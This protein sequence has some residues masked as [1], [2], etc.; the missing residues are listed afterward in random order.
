MIT[1]TK[2]TFAP[3][4]LPEPGDV[5]YMWMGYWDTFVVQQLYTYAQ[6][7]YAIV[8]LRRVH[9]NGMFGA[10]HWIKQ[11]NW[12]KPGQLFH[13]MYAFREKYSLEDIERAIPLVPFL[14]RTY[15]KV[16]RDGKHATIPVEPNWYDYERLI[17]N[18][19]KE[20][21]RKRR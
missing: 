14:S 2:D 12:P 16:M 17:K 10:Q 8:V 11:E 7:P 1:V 18:A 6:D 15:P 9:K 19:K 20:A 13:P 21:E 4:P 5:Y 3:G